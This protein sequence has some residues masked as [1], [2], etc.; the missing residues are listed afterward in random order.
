MDKFLAFC[1]RIGYEF[2]GIYPGFSHTE[3]ILQPWRD[4]GLSHL[5]H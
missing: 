2:L 1:K 5:I 3:E 4:C